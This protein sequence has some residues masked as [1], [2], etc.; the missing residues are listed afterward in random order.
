[1]NRNEQIKQAAYS[2]FCNSS[3]ITFGLQ[4]NSFEE[5]AKW[6]DEH[7]SAE[8]FRHC[9]AML[10]NTC[11]EDGTGVEDSEIEYTIKQRGLV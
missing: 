5:G 10:N 3:S 6:A 7:I 11:F 2:I 4:C 1:M 8:T 9:I